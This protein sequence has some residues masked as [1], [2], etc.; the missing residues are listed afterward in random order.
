MCPFERTVNHVNILDAAM[1]E[2][3]KCS[4]REQVPLQLILGIVYGRVV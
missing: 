4:G 1:Q 2:D 3:D